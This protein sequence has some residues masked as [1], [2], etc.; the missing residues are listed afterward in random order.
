V[1]RARQGSAVA[2]IAGLVVVIGICL[3]VP[4]VFFWWYEGPRTSRDD[5][6]LWHTYMMHG[7]EKSIEVSRVAPQTDPTRTEVEASATLLASTVAQ[8]P[9]YQDYAWAT[10]EGGFAVSNAAVLGRPDARFY[11][12]WNPDYM[13]DQHVLDPTRPES[14]IYHNSEHGMHLVGVMYV[15][16]P[17][18]HGPQPGGALTRWHYHPVVEFCMDDDGV[19][20][21]MAENGT[22]G[23]CPPDMTH[24]PTPEMMHVWLVDNPHGVFAH[25]MA[26]EHDHHATGEPERNVY[27]EFAH[28][29][30]LWIRNRF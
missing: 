26:L 6:D 18:T 16:P 9:P 2:W 13:R 15:A 19:P 25:M 21:T 30:V 1:P 4:P 8:S 28:R 7:G 23:G 29:A 24:G 12:V 27:Q 3:A 11:H 10:T 14:L 20:T 22:R 17:G 5:D